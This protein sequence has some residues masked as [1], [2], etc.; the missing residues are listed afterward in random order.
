MHAAGGA[1]HPQAAL[2]GAPPHSGVAAGQ[3]LGALEVGH[4]SALVP[5][6]MRAL[7]LQT[8]PVTPAHSGATAGQ[9]QSA[10]PPETLQGLPAVQLREDAV[11]QPF[12]VVLQVTTLLFAQT[13][14]LLVPAQAA[15]AALHW[16]E[17][18]PPEPTQDSL[19]P[20][21]FMA[22]T[23]GQP[24]AF[25]PQVMRVVPLVQRLPLVPMH[26]GGAAPHEQEAAG[27]VPVQ[28]LPPGQVLEAPL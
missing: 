7:P 9:R 24:S 17:A 6:V 1:V 2:P 22:V 14:P 13:V 21:V 27:R 11:T 23:A 20:Q 26:A 3:L 25:E 4:P 12:V 18:L 15:G 10:T 19:G 28:G 8:V 5:Q 16:Q